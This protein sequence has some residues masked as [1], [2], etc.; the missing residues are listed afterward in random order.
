M[1][2]RTYRQ[3]Y[4][5]NVGVNLTHRLR[6]PI[7]PDNSFEFI[8]IQE[9]VPIS[10]CQPTTIQPITY[11]HLYC[12]NTPRK[13]LSL[14]PEKL[15]S[16]YKHRIVHYD[17]NLNNPNDGP[18]AAFTY[19]D[20]PYLSPR[21]ASLRHAQPGDLLLFL[22]NLVSFD[23]DKGI[24]NPGPRGLY[25]IGCIEIDFVLEYSYQAGEGRLCNLYSPE[26]DAYDV[27]QFA[28]NA[29]VNRLLTLPHR[30]EKQPFSIFE[31]SSRSQ[32]FQYAVQITKQMCDICLRDKNGQ[33]FDYSKFRSLEA[34]VGAYTRSVRPH[35][36]LIH[37]ADQDRFQ[38]FLDHIGLLNDISIS[39]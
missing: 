13:L 16:N 25:F 19:G 4:L 1:I 37:Q 32:R 34:C 23:P 18:H 6:S 26:Q 38:L 12:H 15:Q 5:V 17:P 27:L 10:E 30:Y 31:G 33:T 28:R 8:P 2:M 21:A 24:F 35:F 22:A 11:D 39:P 36:S 14:F 20:I 9:Q 7:F 29:H 3:V